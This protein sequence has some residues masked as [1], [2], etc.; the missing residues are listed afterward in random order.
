MKAASLLAAFV[1]LQVPVNQTVIE[2]R[3][4][5]LGEGFK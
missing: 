3:I 5:L 4:E 2:R 1:I